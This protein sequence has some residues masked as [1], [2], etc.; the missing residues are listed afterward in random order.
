MFQV[1]TVVAESVIDDVSNG[2]Q[3]MGMQA[4]RNAWRRLIGRPGHSALSIGILSLG[5]L[6]ALF[7]FG[8]VN[9]MVLKPLPFPQAERLVAVGWSDARR[10][11]EVGGLNTRQWLAIKDALPM[12]DRVAVDGGQATVNISQ[13][14]GVKRYN[15]AVIDREL[16][17]LFSLQPLLGRAFNDEDDR[18]GA[19]L[20]VLLGEHVWRNDFGADPG[21]IGRVVRTNGQTATIIGVLPGWFSYPYDQEVWIPRRL[22]L[23]D[24]LGTQLLARLA[25][26]V[27]PEQARLALA[28]L[29]RRMNNEILGGRDEATLN[30]IPLQHRFVDETTRHILWMMFAAGLLVL[31]LACVNVANLQLAAILPRRRELA[32]RSALGA[33]RGRL[34]SELMAEALIM[35]AIATL[36]AAIGNDLL[37][38]V[39]VSHMSSTGLTLPFFVDFGYDWR[40]F[41]FVPVL[42]FVTCLL[43]GLIPAMR[44]AGTDAQ[45][46]LR[47]GSKGSHGGLFAR[48][49]RVLVIGEIALTVILLIGAAMFIRGINGMIGFDHGGRVDPE[50]VLTARVGLFES[51]YPTPTDRARFFERV[52]ERLREDPQVI[53]ASVGTGMPGWT[54]GGSEDVIAEGAERPAGGH[55]EAETAAV[56]PAFAAVYGLTLREGRFFTQAD[57]ADAL[58]VTVIDARAAQRLWPDRPALGQRLV[59][60]PEGDQPRTVT[61]VGVVDNLHLRQ[62]NASPR[63]AV[64]MPFAQ[65]PTRFATVA[66]QLRGDAV[67]FAPRLSDAVR[68]VDP[69]TPAYWVQTHAANIKI[70]RAGAVVLTQMFGAVGLFTLILAA[71]GLYGVLAFSVEQRTREIGIRRAIGSDRIGVA[72]L[73]FRRVVGQL[74]FG[75]GIGIAIALPWSALLANPAFHTQAYDPLIFGSTIAL[76][77]LVALVSALVPLRRALRVDPVVALRQD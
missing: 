36:L 54:S 2:G 22:A 35:A 59:V 24:G 4:F 46:A 67:A 6:A 77:L 50:T 31:L 49:S 10:P 62:V 53:E 68:A 51:D 8:S 30:L 3:V 55:V 21:V 45:D 34:L 28:D 42:A 60:D 63:P 66:V 64:L 27:T 29:T 65:V 61:V 40:D 26:G 44:A 52:A 18:P 73:V 48:I 12:F 74:G 33:G 17:P 41:V 32:V 43:S 25:P 16:L 14:E 15:G 47:D 23:D 56:D 13:A 39:F 7:L 9:S 75:L 69:H 71:A 37:G 19:P 57:H 58:P 72:K 70:G 76:I 38:R 1:G 11:N 5:L 20:T